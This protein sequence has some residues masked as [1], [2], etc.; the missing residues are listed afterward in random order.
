MGALLAWFGLECRRS[1]C[2]ANM[3]E[4][5]VPDSLIEY[6]ELRSNVAHGGNHAT[7][8]VMAIKFPA[9]LDFFIKQIVAKQ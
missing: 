2:D 6:I 1:G 9:G 7:V 5:V 8:E 3:L 4:R